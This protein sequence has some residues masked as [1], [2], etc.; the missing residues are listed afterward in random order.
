MEYE[1]RFIDYLTR[2][3]AA[4]DATLSAYVGDINE[5][6][7]YLKEARSKSPLK[8]AGA[9]ISAFMTSLKESGKSSST[10][11][12]KMSS[13]RSYY[14][15]LASE[16]LVSYNPAAGIKSPKVE[17]RS[18]DYL[19]V[20]EVEKLLASPASDP[21]GLR[22]RALLELMYATGM[23]ASEIAAANIGDIDLRIG[24]IS[25]S[26]GR[27]RIIPIGR[28]ARAALREYLESS[29]PVLTK[30][31]ESTNA[32]F[33]N[34]QGERITRQGIWK[35]MK[36]YAEASG[37]EKPM[38]PQILRNSFAV[39]M[40]QNGA[41]LKSIQDLMGLEDINAAKMYMVVSK[42]RI[43]DVYDKTHPRA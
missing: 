10:I 23:R 25:C 2:E 6:E 30:G 27:G 40:L 8:A 9:D 31:G 15:M 12:R 1:K 32:L 7:A 42:R 37:I 34:F 22:D 39:H 38:N 20:E 28:P 18:I 33:V 24:F 26:E 13:V 35:I 17:D 11:N 29:R 4:S 16:G 5:F 19:E 3:K 36:Q 14:S 43:M 41:D 21:K